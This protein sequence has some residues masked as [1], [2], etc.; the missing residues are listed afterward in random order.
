MRAITFTISDADHAL[1]DMQ[2][3]KHHFATMAAYVRWKLLSTVPEADALPMP[4]I[5]TNLK[6]A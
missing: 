6:G 5:T 4:E 3:R 1:I 2:R